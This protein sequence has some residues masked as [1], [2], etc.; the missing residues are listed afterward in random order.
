[1]LVGLDTACTIFF[2]ES[3]VFF[4][5]QEA[6]I[7]SRREETKTLETELLELV[8]VERKR[9]EVALLEVE[10]LKLE[11]KRYEKALLEVEELKAALEQCR[12]QNSR[13]RQELAE[14]TKIPGSLDYGDYP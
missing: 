2:T 10:E 6:K 4:T 7:C 13:L 14:K 5:V 11:R 12:A 3:R 8:K 1:M 9:V